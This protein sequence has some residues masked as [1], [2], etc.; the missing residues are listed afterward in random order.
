MLSTTFS[1]S[2]PMP[3][4]S[5]C[6]FPLISVGRPARSELKRS[7]RRSSSGSTL[8]LRASSMNSAFSSSSF[9]GI[10]AARSCAW[11]QSL[12]VSYSSQVSSANGGSSPMIHGV[13]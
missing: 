10:S 9:S 7:T 4:K 2:R 1:A 12:F 13:E 8:Y 3:P 11:L 6:D 5:N